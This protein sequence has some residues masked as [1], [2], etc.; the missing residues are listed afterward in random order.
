[1]YGSLFHTQYQLLNNN[2]NNN[3]ANN[4]F[5]LI[6][7]DSLNKRFCKKIF[8]FSIFLLKK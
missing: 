7:N 1:M 8:G 4:Y 3:N 6:I 5:M 2:S